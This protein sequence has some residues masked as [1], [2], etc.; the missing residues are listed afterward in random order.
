MIKNTF[1]NQISLEFRWNF[2]AFRRRPLSADRESS[3]SVSTGGVLSDFD[4][5]LHHFDPKIE[6]LFWLTLKEPVTVTFLM[7]T[8]AIV[9]LVV[10]KL[11]YS[12]YKDNEY[13]V[14]F[15]SFENI[16]FL[17]SLF[18]SISIFRSF[19]F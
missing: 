10:L 14:K 4:P 19:E 5:L 1:E 17:M 2:C 6:H 18:W 7:M 8:I 3:Y 11:V 13:Y 9:V 16:A 15:T 12:R